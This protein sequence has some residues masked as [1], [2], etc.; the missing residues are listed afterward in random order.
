MNISN[1]QINVIFKLCYLCTYTTTPI[2]KLGGFEKKSL[3]F[4]NAA[5]I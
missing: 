3:M 1:E 2:Q 5:F 4:N